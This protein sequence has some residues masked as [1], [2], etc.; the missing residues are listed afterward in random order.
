MSLTAFIANDVV[1]ESMT[2]TVEVIVLC[3][4]RSSSG[5]ARGGECLGSN[6]FCDFNILSN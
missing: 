2:A 6:D 4:V 3:L 1:V 5:T